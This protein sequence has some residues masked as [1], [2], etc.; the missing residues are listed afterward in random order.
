MG[1]TLEGNLI[2]DPHSR[3]MVTGGCGFVGAN[4][5]DRLL[6]A[7]VAVTVVDNLSRRGSAENLA[8]LRGRHG[9]GWQFVDADVRNATAIERLIGDT[10]PDVLAHLAGQVAMTTSIADPRLDF[11]VNT[12]GTFNVLEG[13]RTSSPGTRVIYSSTNKVYGSLDRLRYDEGET[14]YVLPDHPSG[15]DESHPLE[16]ETPYGCSKLAADQYVLDFAHTY[17]LET[18]VFR[19]SSMY[20]GRQFATFD[21]G[22]IGWFCSKALEMGD[23]AAPP[24]TIAGT[25][26]QVRDV[27]QADDLVDAYLRAARAS[28]RATGRAYNIGGGMANSLSLL[29]LFAELEAITGNRLRFERTTAR[30]G[31]QKVFVADLTAAGEQLGWVPRVTKEEGLRLMV[32]WSSELRE[33]ALAN[34]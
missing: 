16:G 9:S 19:H 11:E 5:A 33:G 26:K 31:D 20:G 13:V 23:P 21:Q 27:L 18:V 28:H 34:S 7:G 8:W 6:S 24:F 10:K 3:W 1:A 25:G 4:L 29:E 15:L 17:G 2:P 32:G 14:R 12:G 30:H 22:W